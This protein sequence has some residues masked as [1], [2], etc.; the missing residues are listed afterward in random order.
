MAPPPSIPH[1]DVMKKIGIN[2]KS[3][4]V[5]LLIILIIPFGLT[6]LQMILFPQ[7]FLTFFR[8]LNYICYFTAFFVTFRLAEKKKIVNGMIVFLLSLALVYVPF[9]VIQNQMREFNNG[10]IVNEHGFLYWIPTYSLVLFVVAYIFEKLT[11]KNKNHN[12]AS[13]RNAEHAP[14]AQHP[15]S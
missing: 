4:G 13:E 8:I 1:V 7:R 5:G 2:L 14:R 10:S 9:F 15:S 3:I 12:K 6:L 11:R